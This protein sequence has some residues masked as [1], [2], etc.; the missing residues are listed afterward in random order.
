MDLKN[1]RYFVSVA[2]HGGFLRASR[3]IHVTQPALSKAVQQLEEELGTLLLVRSKPGVPSRLTPSGELVFHHAKA[4]LE[5]SAQMQ[6]DVSL[7]NS[8]AAG[9]LRL[10]LPPLGSTDQVAATLTE[11]HR[12]F[13]QVELQ[14]LEQGGLELEEAVRK[15]EVELAISLR[16]DGADLAWHPICEEPLVVT[17]PPRH[18]LTHRHKLT[19]ADLAEQPWVRLLGASILNRR[20]EQCCP[21]LDISRR[22]VAQSGNLAFCLSLVAAGAG[23]MVLPRLLAQHHIPPGVETVP[24]ECGDLQWLLT[25]IWRKNVQ[26]SVAAQRCLELLSETA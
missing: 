11:F 3:R 23:V 25:V 6:A 26:L 24:L 16:P 4:L 19:L 18:P 12:R 8:L 5:R 14:L 22:Q 17:L 1:L 21:G 20:I 9:T 7:L 10:G 15:G 2:Q 13:P